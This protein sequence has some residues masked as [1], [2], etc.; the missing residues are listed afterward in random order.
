MFNFF[1]RQAKTLNMVCQNTTI[2]ED[3]YVVVTPDRPIAELFK[4]IKEG[5]ND[6]INQRYE[7]V[8]P[9]LK[10]VIID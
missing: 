6:C 9:L 2:G 3:F 7:L 4:L 10:E 1:F 5:K 8:L